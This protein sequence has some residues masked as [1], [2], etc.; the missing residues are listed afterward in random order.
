MEGLIGVGVG[1]LVLGL[2][3][4]QAE[5]G[6]GHRAEEGAFLV[7]LRQSRDGFLVSQA[8][9]GAHRRL[10]DPGCQAVFSDF[11]D[12][13]GRTLQDV[14]D[15][16]GETGQSHLQRLF[17]Y[18]GA[19]ARGCGAPGVLAFTQPGSQVVYVCNRRFREAFAANP[20]KVEAV[21]IHES[22]H[23][24]GLGENPPRS[25]DITARVMQRCV[26]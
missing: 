25:E 22:L 19:E 4:V 12:S 16:R 14:L 1:V 20:S 9:R 15:E 10:A 6:G 24:L 7:R 18:D 8:V 23:S 17:F 26:F 3:G 2:Q 21:I 13:S 11:T 5:P